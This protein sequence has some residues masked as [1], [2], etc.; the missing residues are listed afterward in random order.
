M[1]TGNQDRRGKKGDQQ[2]KGRA[3]CR[4]FRYLSGIRTGAASNCRGE[5][6]DRQPGRR[7]PVIDWNQLNRQA[8]KILDWLGFGHID[9]RE[10]GREPFRCL[11]AGGGDQQS[12]LTQFQ[13]AGV[14]RTDG[15][16][17]VERRKTALQDHRDFK[18]NRASVS[19]IF[20]TAS[21]RFLRC[22]I[23]ITVLKDGKK[24]GHCDHQGYYGGTAGKND[25]RPR[26][27]GDVPAKERQDRRRYDEGGTSLLREK[28]QD[29]SFEV[30][31]GKSS[32]STASS[33]QGGQ[34]TL[35]AVFGADKK[36][37]GSVILGGTPVQITSS[38]KRYRS[39]S[40]CCPRIGKSTECSSI[41]R[42]A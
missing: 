29:V 10:K 8:R 7:K 18:K 11:P 23:K 19:F 38:K 1:T 27:H 21:A 12:A 26:P 15:G 9:V 13:R 25:G 33:A 4:D 41:S 36:D 22:A 42:S 20:P 40:G 14:R 39:G 16:A 37:S 24:R 31:E 2:H 28:V 17:C 5:Y 35:R 34:E 3:R 30:R 32:E 6:T